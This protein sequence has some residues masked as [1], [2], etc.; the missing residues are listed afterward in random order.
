[1][2]WVKKELPERKPVVV[3][4][5]LISVLRRGGYFNTQQTSDELWFTE[6]RQPREGPEKEIVTVAVQMLEEAECVDVSQEQITIVS[7]NVAKDVVA[8][9]KVCHFSEVMQQYSV[10]ETF[11][12]APVTDYVGDEFSVD[13]MDITRIRAYLLGMYVAREHPDGNVL[14][15]YLLRNKPY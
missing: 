4:H 15:R 11:F 1:V 2:E 10:Q 8:K 9:H 3:P 13:E 12:D 7:S 14:V 5:R 6:S